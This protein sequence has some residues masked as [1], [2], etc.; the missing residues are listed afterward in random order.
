MQRNALIFNLRNPSWVLSFKVTALRFDHLDPDPKAPARHLQL[1]H[2][3]KR[4][5]RG[6]PEGDHVGVP[7][8]I[9]DPLEVTARSSREASG[10]DYRETKSEH[11]QIV[12]GASPLNLAASESIWRISSWG[13]KLRIWDLLERSCGWWGRS[14]PRRPISWARSLSFSK[15]SLGLFKYSELDLNSVIS[16]L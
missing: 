15:W 9:G 3:R 7:G 10:R 8:L 4:R 13:R 11:E 1:V 5:L 12:A 14:F 16:K 6:D 2:S